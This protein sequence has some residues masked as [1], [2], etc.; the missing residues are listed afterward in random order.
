MFLI[1]GFHEIR[2]GKELQIIQRTNEFVSFKR[3]RQISNG[4]LEL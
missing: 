4:N 1:T 3:F 2:S